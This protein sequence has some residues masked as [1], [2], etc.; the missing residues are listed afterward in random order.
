M[1][2]DENVYYS[3]T[4]EEFQNP[5]TE[6]FASPDVIPE[7]ELTDVSQVGLLLGFI[8]VGLF[9][10]YANFKVIM[11]E[12]KRHA[13]FEQDIEEAELTLQNEYK[14]DQAELDQI[15]REFAQIESGEIGQKNGEEDDEMAD[16][17]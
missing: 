7:L 16:I 1:A 8:S 15:K 12:M 11:D 2:Q 14:V 3:S 13:K 17:N 9:I 5:F 6:T 4:G 10:L